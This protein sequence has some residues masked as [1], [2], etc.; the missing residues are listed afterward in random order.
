MP[1][2]LEASE[3][4]PSIGGSGH[5]AAAL[6]LSAPVCGPVVGVPKLTVYEGSKGHVN[7]DLDPSEKSVVADLGNCH[8]AL[9]IRGIPGPGT[10]AEV[11]K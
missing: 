11:A 4:K 8:G 6:L 7:S 1:D 2:L 10:N 5:D 9:H 3:I